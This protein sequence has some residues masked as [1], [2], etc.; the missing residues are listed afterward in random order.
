MSCSVHDLAALDS[1]GIPGVAVASSAFQ[2]A[3]AAQS[4]ALG[5]PAPVVFV[6]HPVQDRTDE[7][8]RALAD[9]AVDAVLAA[10]TAAPTVDP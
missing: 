6:E 1:S 9:A 3:A 7:E 5:F 4:A 2:Q 10:V 8:M